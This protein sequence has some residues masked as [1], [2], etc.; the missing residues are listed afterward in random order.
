MRLGSDLTR[1]FMSKTFAELVDEALARIEKRRLEILPC[2][3]CRERLDLDKLDSDDARNDVSNV[4]IVV[5][6]HR[7]SAIGN[8]ITL[9]FY[10]QYMKFQ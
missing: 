2:T 5:E 3:Q 1:N 8:R 10:R 4:N 6:K 9:K 7:N